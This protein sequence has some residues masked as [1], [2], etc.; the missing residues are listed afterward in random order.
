MTV[1]APPVP[2][3]PPGERDDAIANPRF[4]RAPSGSAPVSPPPAIGPVEDENMEG[5]RLSGR[6]RTQR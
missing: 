3:P 6:G 1:F 4:A 5:F 2:R